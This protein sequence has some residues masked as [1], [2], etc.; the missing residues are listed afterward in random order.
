MVSDGGWY[1]PNALML[2]PLEK[3]TDVLAMGDAPVCYCATEIRGPLTGEMVLV[4]DDDSGLALADLLLDRPQGATA[5]W[6]ELAQSAALE[7]SN[8]LSCGFL[9]ALASCLS[10]TD[11]AE[12]LPTPPRFGRDFAESVLEFALMSQAAAADQIILTQTQFEI[13]GSPFSWTL[14]LAPDA[15]SMAQMGSL[16]SCA[17]V[18][19]EGG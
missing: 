1:R 15:Q 9:N 10:I 3:A 19:Q 13:A 18:E 17:A 7:T 12:L 5:E 2:L 16:F 6:S 8:I 4:F 14:V 11:N